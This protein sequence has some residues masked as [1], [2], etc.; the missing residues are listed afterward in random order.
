MTTMKK[1]TSIGYLDRKG[2]TIKVGDRIKSL[3]DGTIYVIDKY[4]H[5]VSA[6]GFRHNPEGLGPVSRGMNADGTYYA[7]LDE[8]VVTDE[9]A[10]ATPEGEVVKPG[11]DSDNMAPDRVKD[12]RNVKLR[13]YTKDSE[14]RAVQEGCT[15]SEAR[16]ILT[17]Q[18]FTVEEICDELRDRG[19]FGQ[20]TKRIT[21]EK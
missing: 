7:R 2:D 20:V 16:R 6:L 3:Q 4:G 8:L 19:Y 12:P 9:P 10:P 1:G 5:A 15:P 17:L 21:I 11:S 14:D 13:K 18:D